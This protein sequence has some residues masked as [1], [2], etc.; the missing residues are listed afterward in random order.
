MDLVVSRA[1]EVVAN[2][3]DTF[4][5]SS[6]QAAITEEINGLGSRLVFPRY[7]TGRIRVSEQEARFLFAKA[8]ENSSL[9]YSVETPTIELYQQRG[10]EPSRASLDLTV[11]DE[12]GQPLVNCEF[13]SGG[14]SLKRKDSMAISKDLEKLVQDP[15][16]GL[17]FI[18]YVAP[19]TQR[20]PVC[21]A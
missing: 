1:I 15:G 10:L 6:Y 12:Y 18:S 13:K 19:T 2:H 4:L 5:W 7:A 9:R 16:N 14:T 11:R 8:L 20:S 3:T 17:W 21:S